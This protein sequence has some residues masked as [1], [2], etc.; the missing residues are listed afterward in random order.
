MLPE[1]CRNNLRQLPLSPGQIFGPAAQ[2][3]LE[4]T[5]VRAAESRS[6][7]IGCSVSYTALAAQQLHFSYIIG[8]ALQTTSCFSIH[9]RKNMV[10]SSVTHPQWAPRFIRQLYAIRIRSWPFPKLV[11]EGCNR[12]SEPLCPLKIF[13]CSGEG[14]FLAHPGSQALKQEP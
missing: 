13:Y 12:T 5:R 4:R 8:E 7:Y 2:E 10:F 1:V 14:W 11:G 3:A 6:Q 9:S